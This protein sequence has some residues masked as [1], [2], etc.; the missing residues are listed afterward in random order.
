MSEQEFNQNKSGYGAS[1]LCLL[2]FAEKVKKIRSKYI[3]API[4]AIIHGGTELCELPNPNYRKQ[5][6][7][8][9]ELG[10]SIVVGHH[11]HVVSGIE[12]YNGKPIVYSLGNFLFDSDKPCES[13]ESGA[14]IDIEFDENGSLINIMML[15]VYNR[16]DCFGVRFYSGDEKKHREELVKNISEIIADE[17]QYTK[18]WAD[19]ALDNFEGKYARLALPFWFKGAGFLFR[20]FKLSWFWTRRSLIPYQLNIIRCPAHRQVLITELERRYEQLD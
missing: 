3:N 4:I 1:P 10:A 12:Y 13:W 7:L 14:L 8:L 18:R 5:C 15:P 17:N 20:K 16:V 2:S 6:K 11:S 9:I 19:F